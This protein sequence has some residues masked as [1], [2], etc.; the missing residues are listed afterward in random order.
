MYL[1]MYNTYQ[2]GLNLWSMHWKWQW[3]Y[4]RSITLRIDP[5]YFV[6]NCIKKGM[7]IFDCL[8]KKYVTSC[9]FT[10]ING[11]LQYPDIQVQYHWAF[12]I[13]N[14]RWQTDRITMYAPE[15]ALYLVHNIELKEH[16]VILTSSFLRHYSID[17]DE[18]NLFPKILLILTLHCLLRLILCFTLGWH[19]SIGHCIV[20][21]FCRHNKI[22]NLAIILPNLSILYINIVWQEVSV[23]IKI[24]TFLEKKF[25]WGWGS[26][27]T[28]LIVNRQCYI[29]KKH[30]PKKNCILCCLHAWYR[31]LTV[32]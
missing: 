32:R 28:L 8:Y 29:C 17:I 10:S 6:L 7:C 1:E 11:E 2:W 16:F 21:V 3:S 13:T 24:S 23:E 18:K 25:R 22:T 14:C 20:I 19:C 9:Y 30:K 5:L 27:N 31:S 15:C 26:R 12:N 4:W